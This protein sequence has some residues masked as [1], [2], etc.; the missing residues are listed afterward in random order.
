MSAR[1]AAARIESDARPPDVFQ[2]G[3]HAIEV[4]CAAGRWSVV[5]DQVPLS[6]WYESRV[7]A[8]EAG[9]REASRLDGVGAI[10]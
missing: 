9:V 7:E 4:T 6:R 5:V 1:Y 10:A 2:V 8:W 3:L